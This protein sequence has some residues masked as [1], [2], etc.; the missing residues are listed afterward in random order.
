VAIFL[1]NRNNF[2]AGGTRINFL[3]WND[4]IVAITPIYCNIFPIVVM[5]SVAVDQ[6]I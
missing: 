2:S 1:E 5:G 4:K 6:K 3:Q